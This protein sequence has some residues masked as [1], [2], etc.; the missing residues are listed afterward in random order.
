M[1]RQ[2]SKKQEARSDNDDDDDD[3]PCIKYLKLS[4]FTFTL[5]TL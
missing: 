4:S 5:H 1:R 2:R 3:E